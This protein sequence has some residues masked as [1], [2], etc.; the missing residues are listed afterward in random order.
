[1]YSI[2]IDDA[3]LHFSAAH[4]I[5]D[6]A[7][8]ERIHGH[9]YQVEVAV[10]GALNEYGMVIDFRDIKK[11]VKE[12]CNRLDH[13]VILPLDSKSIKVH[14]SEE[15]VT[16]KIGEKS[17]RFPLEDCLLLPVKATTAELLAEFIAGEITIS[18][19]LSL[20]I[21][22]SENTGSRGCFARE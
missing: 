17:Y 14:K 20:E 1:M 3:S 7:G 8:V 12:I 4:F 2:K 15:N 11:M 21:C 16:V 18:K 19:K 5:E 9:N 10:I 13:R 22:V 6:S